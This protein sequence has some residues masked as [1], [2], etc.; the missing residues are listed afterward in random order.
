M[1]ER[2]S[3][4]AQRLLAALRSGA[5][6]LEGIARARLSP[7]KREVLLRYKAVTVHIRAAWACGLD[8]SKYSELMDAQIYSRDSERQ[9]LL[10]RLTQLET[11]NAT[12]TAQKQAL[13]ERVAALESHNAQ[14]T[15]SAT[16]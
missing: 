5:G 3:E 13:L 12:L 7:L 14:L 6:R 15:E 2:N 10:A 1:S 4:T 8:P 9:A 16:E 11:D